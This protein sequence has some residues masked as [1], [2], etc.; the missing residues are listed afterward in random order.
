M[1]NSVTLPTIGVLALVGAG[2]GIHLGNASIAEISPHYF[3]APQTRFHADLSPNRSGT[4]DA[5][6]IREDVAD[7]GLLGSGCVGCRDFPEEYFP[8][9]DSSIDS[10]IEGAAPAEGAVQLSVVPV[11]SDVALAERQG[12]LD[13]VRRYASYSISSEQDP[14]GQE[15][16]QAPGPAEQ[17]AIQGAELEPTAVD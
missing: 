6:E 14:T 9:R 16:A 4:T 10:A 17:S 13:R 12:A 11:E 2:L 5:Y 7:A 3:S 1:A 8:V 15:R